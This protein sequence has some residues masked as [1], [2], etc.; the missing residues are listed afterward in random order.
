MEVFP[1][2]IEKENRRYLPFLLSTT[3]LMAAVKAG[4]GRETAH[5]AIKEHALATA[6]ELRDGLIG[7]NNLLDRLANDDRIPL[8]RHDLQ[9]VFE[10]AQ[11]NTGAGCRPGRLLRQARD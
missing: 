1:G 5:E 2:T 7:E 11:G 4:A 9:E 6:A 10:S 8:T 3:F